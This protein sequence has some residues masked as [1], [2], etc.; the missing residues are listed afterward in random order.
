MRQM[1]ERARQC[2]SHAV[3]AAAAATLLACTTAK[4]PALRVDGSALT[5]ALNATLAKEARLA[6]VTKVA[7]NSATGVVTLSGRVASAEER[8]L[9]GRLACSVKGVSVVYNELEVQHAVR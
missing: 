7:V 3:A 5:S 8:E 1:S 2:F 9:A 4:A 6:R